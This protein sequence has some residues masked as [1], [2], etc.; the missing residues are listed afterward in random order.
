MIKKLFLLLFVFTTLSY[1]QMF[2]FGEVKGLF[3][4][5]GVGPRMPLGDF[6]NA[7]GIGSGL[8]MSL[9][10]TDNIIVPVFIYGTIGYQHHPGKQDFY[11]GTDYSSIS[12]NLYYG[13]LGVRHYFTPLVENVI[14]LMPVIDGGVSVAFSETSHQYSIESGRNNSS[15]N[16]VKLGGHIGAG[17]SMFLMDVMAYYNYFHNNQFLSIDLRVNIPIFVSY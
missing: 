15:E 13:N 9:L 5:V 8:D 2:K 7:H 12:T 17:F 4:S 3:M 6:A 1:G 11:K 10:Y 14:L 16:L